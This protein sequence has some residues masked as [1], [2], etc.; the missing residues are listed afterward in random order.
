MG[1][2]TIS[3]S[4]TGF[5]QTVRDTGI[6]R[7]SAGQPSFKVL[8]MSA[9]TGPSPESDIGRVVGKATDLAAGG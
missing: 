9:R 8:A 7:L 5:C 2:Q 1:E 6:I 3:P 4:T